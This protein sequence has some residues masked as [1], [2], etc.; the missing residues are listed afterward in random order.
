VGTGPGGL[1]VGGLLRAACLAVPGHPAVVD[2]DEV[3]TYGSLHARLAR[4]GALLASRGLGAGDRV[5]VISRNRAEYLAV[6]AAAEV[7]GLVLVPVNFRL[8][9][10]EMVYVLE[11]SGARAVFLDGEVL[12]EAGGEL[13]SLLPEVVLWVAWRGRV[14]G[15]EDWADWLGGAPPGGGARD[16]G[17]AAVPGA[18]GEAASCI[19]YTSGTTGRPKGAVLT[20][21]TQALSALLMALQLGLG[22]E[23]RVLVVMPLHHVGGKW[24]SLAAL[25]R[26][27]TVVLQPAFDAGAVAAG[28][29]AHVITVAL[30]APTMIYRLLH[31]GGAVD[32]SRLRSLKTVLYSSAPMAPDLLAE[33]LD[34]LGPVFAQV[35]GSTES[36]SVTWYSR[37]EHREAVESGARHRLAA[38]GRPSPGAEVVIAADDGSPLDRGR[39]GEIWARAPWVFPG[40]WRDAP[41]TAAAF[42]GAWLRTGDVG[43]IDADGF[44]YVL[45]R[46][47]DLIISGGE[48]IYP[49]EVEDLL[50][51]HPAV[52]EAAVVGVPD[53]EWGE[54]VKAFV[55]LRAGAAAAPA[56]LLAFCRG[57]IA[58]YKRPREVEVVASLPKNSVGKVLRRLLRPE[59]GGGGAGGPAR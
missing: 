21:G 52:D 4:V 58:G 38:A 20:Q 43:R 18:A 31:A 47:S 16:L 32:P 11:Q 24:L 6:F 40:Y 51:T 1:T 9:V 50:L 44:V 57:R 25:C 26:G 59:P 45:D 27:A 30:L 33:G 37:Q 5:A 28:V 22:R 19:Y 49:R 2:G 29:A 36:G 34:A 48:N 41:A 23:D 35:Y 3:W 14:D 17:D 53:A 13:R 10:P 46:K 55:V 54:R 39:E 15:F 12:A 8:S 56:D 7:F 42:H